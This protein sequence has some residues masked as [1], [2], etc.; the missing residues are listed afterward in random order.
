MSQRKRSRRTKPSVTAASRTTIDNGTCPTC[1]RPLSPPLAPRKICSKCGKG[2]LRGHKFHYVT[3]TK[4]KQSWTQ[5][6]HRIC[7]EPDA[8]VPEKLRKELYK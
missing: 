5:L 6:Q 1:G 7:E 2:I 3:V 8:Y 4:G